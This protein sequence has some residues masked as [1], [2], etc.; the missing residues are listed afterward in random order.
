ERHR[1]T[2]QNNESARCARDELDLKRQLLGHS[3]G[4]VR[5]QQ[6]IIDRQREEISFY[7]TKLEETVQ[8]RVTNNAQSD[9]NQTDVNQSGNGDLREREIP[10]EN[11][12]SQERGSNCGSVGLPQESESGASGP[13]NGDFYGRR[14]GVPGKF[15]FRGLCYKCRLPGHRQAFCTGGN[16]GPRL[17]VSRGQGAGW[18]GPS[19]G[20]DGNWRQ[21]PG[22]RGQGWQN[23]GWNRSQY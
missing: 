1:I 4:M 9:R 12:F 6:E 11:N 17:M 14:S 20:H 21:G 22:W 3:R 5:Q 15:L 16:V 13:V 18:R 2:A 19:Q 23:G 10:N 8:G 7:K